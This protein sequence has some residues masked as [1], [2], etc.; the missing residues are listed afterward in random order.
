MGIIRSEFNL[1]LLAQGFGQSGLTLYLSDLR[2]LRDLRGE[3][4]FRDAL[5]L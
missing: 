3:N 4:V 1:D 2:G 5:H